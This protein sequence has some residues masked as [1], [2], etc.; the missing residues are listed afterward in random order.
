MKFNLDRRFLFNV[1]RIIFGLFFIVSGFTKLYPIEPFEFQ[2]VDTGISNW[3]LAPFLARILIG[4]EV[5]LGVLFL[6]GIYLKQARIATAILLVFFSVYL[7]YIRFI[8][9]ITEDCGCFGVYLSMGPIPSLFKNIA[10]LILLF[11]LHIN[12]LFLFELKKYNKLIFSILFIVVFALPFILNPIDIART[13][14][15]TSEKVGKPIEMDLFDNTDFSGDTINLKNGNKVVCFFS[16]TCP[17]CKLAAKKLAILEKQHDNKLPIYFVFWGT[18]QK[19]GEL[20]TKFIK[21]TNCANVHNKYLDTKSFLTL[22]GP[23]LPAI[24]YLQDGIIKN[25]TAYRDLVPDEVV[26]FLK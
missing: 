17:V 10:L 5:F 11:L 26:D 3:T 1:L 14:H 12:H 23:A 22:S 2:I 19:V 8:L 6:V 24:Y 16:L 9:G 25:K 21:E 4:L 15:M 20:Y 7:I 18:P 13:Y